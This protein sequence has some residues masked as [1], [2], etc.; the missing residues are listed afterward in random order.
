MPKKPKLMLMI[1]Q[2]ERLGLLSALELP[3]EKFA[4]AAIVL[5]IKN[6]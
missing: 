5:L 4:V 2:N 3:S 6:L 1:P